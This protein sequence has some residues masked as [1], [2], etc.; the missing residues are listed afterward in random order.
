MPQIVSRQPGAGRERKARIRQDAVGGARE[1]GEAVTDGIGNTAGRVDGLGLSVGA[2]RLVAALET[3]GSAFPDPA[4]LPDL[5]LSLAAEVVQADGASLEQVDGP[6]LVYTHGYGLL[7]D[8]VGTRMMR[9]T[10]MSGLVV[11]TGEA[12]I[13]VDTSADER[14][15]VETCRRLGIGSMVVLPMRG[16]LDISAVLK[17][18]SSAPNALTVDHLDLLRPLATLAAARFAH[19]AQNE[20]HSAAASLVS[21]VGEASREILVS[22]EPARELCRW[23]CRLVDAPHALVLEP[24]A[25]GALVTSAQSGYELPKVRLSPDEPSIAMAAFKS[26]RLQL[27]SDYRSKPEVAPHVVELLDNSSAPRTSSVA[28]VPL[29]AGGRAVGVL[30]VLLRDKISAAN[31]EVLGLVTMLADEAGLAVERNH[32]Q[33]KLEQQARQDDLTG[34]PNRRVWRERL[35]LEM[36]RA[37]RSLSPL[38]LVLLDVD[39]FKAFNDTH[40]HQGGDAA[41]RAV[42]VTWEGRIRE[43]DLLARL[44]GEEFA[45]VLPETQLA[46]AEGTA[47]RLLRELPM[48]L[49][50]SAGVAQ[51][52]GEDA[53]SF[54]RRADEALY[55]AKAA[56]RNRFHVAPV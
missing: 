54:Y 31:V 19:A 8:S 34:L 42:S 39:H 22:P 36:A 1:H 3:L 10:S 28:Y 46:E 9:A 20:A 53:D 55:G 21:A 6:E 35:R 49:T 30:A 33:Q 12:Q 41:L 5:L 24:D 27:I 25:S 52:G 48:D 16:S 32:L 37:A 14:V 15:D 47:G 7:E 13:S 38:C 56:G 43:T 17:V 40:G 29:T 11:T 4:H 51:W 45:V 2:A 26:A 50:A 18:A 44:G 23:A